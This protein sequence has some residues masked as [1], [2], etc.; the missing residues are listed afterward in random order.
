MKILKKVSIATVCAKP[1]AFFKTLEGEVPMMRLVGLA[2][3]YE[4][5]TS[6]YGEFLKF[7]GEFSAT[8]LTTGEVSI[9]A[10]AF[11]PGP[12]DALLKL[13]IDE[14]GND[15]K[16]PVEFAFDISVV[17]DEKSEVGFQY[18]VRTLTES[19]V[20]DPLAALAAR[21]GAPKLAAP[22][23]KSAPTFEADPAVNTIGPGKEAAKAESVA[24]AKK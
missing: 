3:R 19:K 22:E 16:T 15:G 6:L 8:D 11:L 18:R 10:T 2:R 17:P 21:V 23:P 13:Q 12:V 14:L 20:S 1:K 24:K 7:S 4:L 5:G 9:G